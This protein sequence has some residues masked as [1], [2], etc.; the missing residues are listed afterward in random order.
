MRTVACGN[1]EAWGGWTTNARCDRAACVFAAG[2]GAGLRRARPPPRIASKAPPHRKPEPGLGM[3]AP[4]SKVIHAG[5]TGSRRGL[6]P[7]FQGDGASGCPDLEGRP[8]IG[9]YT[10]VPAP[11]CV[12]APPPFPPGRS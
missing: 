2:C 6:V 9:L 5:R 1:L 11:R 3:S 8:E 10:D 12:R 4:I 7:G